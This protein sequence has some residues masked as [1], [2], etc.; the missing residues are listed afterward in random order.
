LIVGAVALVLSKPNQTAIKAPAGTSAAS[1]QV[2]DV[3][4]AGARERG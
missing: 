4:L 3:P 1:V 2:I